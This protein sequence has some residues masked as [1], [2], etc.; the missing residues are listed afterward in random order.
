MLLVLWAVILPSLRW[1][2]PH[3]WA[4][5]ES[6]ENVSDS[7]SIC[8]SAGLDSPPTLRLAE[9]FKIIA[10]GFQF[11]FCA[12]HKNRCQGPRLFGRCSGWKD[13]VGGSVGLTPHSIKQLAVGGKQSSLERWNARVTLAANDGPQISKWQQKGNSLRINWS[14]S[15]DLSYDHTQSLVLPPLTPPPSLSASFFLPHSSRL[16]SHV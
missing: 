16:V 12:I 1:I 9:S 13:W 14:S 15:Q 11:V 3:L 6:T 5:I 10:H 2:Y 8:I 4:G 7:L